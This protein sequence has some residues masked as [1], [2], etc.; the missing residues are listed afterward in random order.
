MPA[1]KPNTIFPTD[2]EDAIITAAALS[3]S[4]A[5]P[6]TDREWE[7]VKPFLSIGKPYLKERV[8]LD[9]SSD[10]LAAFR[11]AGNDW[12]VRI[13]SALKQWLIEHTA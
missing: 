13:D 1:L 2:E 3:D 12:Q 7:D 4:D 9:L 8:S 11:S 10:V 6:L 5:M